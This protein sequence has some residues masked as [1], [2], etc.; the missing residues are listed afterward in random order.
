MFG[1]KKQKQVV[2]II[3]DMTSE[4]HT[5]QNFVY[6]IPEGGSYHIKSYG[7]GLIITDKDGD[8]VQ[9]VSPQAGFTVSFMPVYK[10]DSA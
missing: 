2:S 10:E 6:S 7:D 8:L 9:R 5:H 4:H 3:M 1:K